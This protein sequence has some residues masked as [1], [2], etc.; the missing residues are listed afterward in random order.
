MAEK[1][2]TGKKGR[3]FGRQV[4]SLS[5]MRYNLEKRWEKNKKRRA[6]KTANRFGH[7]VKIKIDGTWEMIFSR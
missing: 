1:K 4:R 3:K 6:Q 5:H 7:P 2:K